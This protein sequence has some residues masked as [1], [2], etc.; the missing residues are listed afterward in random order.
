MVGFT[1]ISHFHSLATCLQ[2]SYF[3][4]T[5]SSY[6]LSLTVA[7]TLISPLSSSFHFMYSLRVFDLG[8]NPTWIVSSYLFFMWMVFISSFGRFIIYYKQAIFWT[9]GIRYL[10]KIFFPI[11]ITPPDLLYSLEVFDF[12]RVLGS[13]LKVR[14]CR[15][16]PNVFIKQGTVKDCL[17]WWSWI[18]RKH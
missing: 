7:L 2:G 13:L 3:W 6:V 18:N 15:Q 9:S 8:W 4:C 14:I 16:N 12:G 5:H 10:L 11:L 1:D 17:F